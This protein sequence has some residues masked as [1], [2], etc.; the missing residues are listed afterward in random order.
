MSAE[1]EVTKRRIF[2]ELIVKR[3]GTSINPP[4]VT[5]DEDSSFT[6]YE[7]D[8]VNPRIIP[9]IDDPVDASSRAIDQQPM[10]DWLIH[11][12]IMMQQDDNLKNAKV[13]GRSV[14]PDGLTPAGTYHNNPILNSIVYDIEFPDG[15]VKEYAANII[16][17]I[18]A[19][20]S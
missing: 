19:F 2:D 12:E 11:A 5:D 1:T 20:T 9:E 10:Y 7:D 3:H 4:L 6:E 14:G 16:A 18:H 8:E 15:Q 17:D 13:I